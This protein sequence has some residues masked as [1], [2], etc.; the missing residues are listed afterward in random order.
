MFAPTLLD[1]RQLF[2][3]PAMFD[4]RSSWR[5]AAFTV[6]GNGAESDVM[7]ASHPSAKGYLFKKYNAKISP[8]KQLENYRCRVEGAQRLQD[9]ITTQ[10][11]TRIVVPGKYLHKLPPEFCQ[12]KEPAY[13][14]IVERLTLLDSTRSKQQYRQIDVE[15]LRQLCVVIRMFRGLGSGVRNVPFTDKGQIAFV[16][17]ERWADKKKDPLRRI[18]PYLSNERR[19]LAAKILQK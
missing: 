3:D 16:D 4:S 18:N 5:K 19:E 9:L 6:E 14:L 7:V 1:L 13:V 10:H 12:K 2:R 8:K 11:L 15:T 17:T